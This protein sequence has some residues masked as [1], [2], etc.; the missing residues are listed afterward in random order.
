MDKGGYFSR[1]FKIFSY[2][3][4]RV[5]KHSGILNNRSR[6]FFSFYISTSSSLILASFLA[7]RDCSSAILVPIVLQPTKQ[8][9]NNVIMCCGSRS[10]LLWKFGS[11][12]RIKKTII[13]LVKLLKL[14][15]TMNYV[16]L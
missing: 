4:L 16:K 9:M 12:K 5:S 15:M 8:T 7:S 11:D 6:I 3:L 10:G 14:R 2:D 13:F 1:V